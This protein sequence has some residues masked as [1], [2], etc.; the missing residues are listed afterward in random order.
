MI[1]MPPIFVRHFL[2]HD[3]YTLYIPGG[4]EIE[5]QEADSTTLCNRQ[6]DACTPVDMPLFT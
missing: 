5:E 4:R 3:G 6:N 1:S 2:F